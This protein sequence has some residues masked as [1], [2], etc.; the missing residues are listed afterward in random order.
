MDALTP[1]YLRAHADVDCDIV[2]LGHNFCIKTNVL[3]RIEFTS[4]GPDLIGG[5][6]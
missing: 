2:F 1:R 4:K 5:V 3:N 6:Y